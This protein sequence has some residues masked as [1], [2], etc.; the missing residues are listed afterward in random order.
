MSKSPSDLVA[1]ETKPQVEHR[2]CGR[3]A[4]PNL[5]MCSQCDKNGGCELARFICDIIVRWEMHTDLGAETPPA[6]AVLLRQVHDGFV[7]T[8]MGVSGPP[9]MLQMLPQSFTLRIADEM[10]LDATQMSAASPGAFSATAAP[11][12]TALQRSGALRGRHTV[13]GV[14]TADCHQELL[15]IAQIH[16]ASNRCGVASR[17]V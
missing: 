6:P 4:L 17:R 11:T 2:E 10:P 16:G 15:A 1:Q 12:S 8:K 14:R 7:Q 3:Q 9:A 13:A 5:Y